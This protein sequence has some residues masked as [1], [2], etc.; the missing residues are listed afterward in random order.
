MSVLLCFAAELLLELQ[1]V[2][3]Q[4]MLVY[5]RHLPLQCFQV[6]PQAGPFMKGLFVGRASQ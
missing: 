2:I 1:K 5:R 4:S 3:G 6:F